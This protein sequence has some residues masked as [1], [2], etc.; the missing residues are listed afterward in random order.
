M[1]TADQSPT[2][3][4]YREISMKEEGGG[5]GWLRERKE[6]EQAFDRV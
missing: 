5:G 2:I 1:R 4:Y 3:L 6:E